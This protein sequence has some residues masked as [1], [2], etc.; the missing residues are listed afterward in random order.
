MKT[1]ILAPLWHVLAHLYPDESSIRRIA[2]ESG[3]DLSRVPLNSTPKNN[4]HS[5][6]K[7]AEKHHQINALL[8]VV[9]REYGNNEDFRSAC[10]DYRRSTGQINLDDNLGL[11]RQVFKNFLLGI[12]EL[13]EN[14]LMIRSIEHLL[15]HSNS[16]TIDMYAVLDVLGDQIDLWLPKC[17][18]LSPGRF[19]EFTEAAILVY[20]A[21]LRK[22]ENQ[23]PASPVVTQAKSSITKWLNKSSG[24]YNLSSIE[25]AITDCELK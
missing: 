22:C 4:W 2:A 1:E 15:H 18:G 5:V 9:E 19:H 24:V 6:L 7:E 20:I 13:D 14:I 25:M 10:E 11:S 3:V 23:N 21:I 12:E 8:V 16:I 17:E